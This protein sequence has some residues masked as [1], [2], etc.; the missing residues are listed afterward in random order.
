MSSS[1]H[2]FRSRPLSCLIHRLLTPHP[3]HSS[4][5]AVALLSASPMSSAATDASGCEENRP[6]W[7][8]FADAS[9]PEANPLNGLNI[10]GQSRHQLVD[11]DLDGDLDM[12]M[13]LET[14][15]VFYE[16]TGTPQQAVLA[17]SELSIPEALKREQSEDLSF[18]KGYPPPLSPWL[19]LPRYLQDI[20]NDGDLDI[21]KGGKTSNLMMYENQGHSQHSVFAQNPVGLPTCSQTNYHLGDLD[22]DGDLDMLRSELGDTSVSY[23]ENTGTASQ[24]EFSARSGLDDPVLNLEIPFKSS[25]ALVDVDQDRDLDILAGLENGRLQFYE[26]KGTPQSPSF[27][28]NS[29]AENPFAAVNVGSLATPSL[30]DLDKDGDLD[31]LVSNAEGVFTYYENTGSEALRP[32]LGWDKTAFAQITIPSSLSSTKMESHV[33]ALA[34]LDHDGDLDLLIGTKITAMTGDRRGRQDILY[35]ENVGSSQ[36]A[37]FIPR[38]EAQSP[39]SHILTEEA[40]S[41]FEGK[42]GAIAAAISLGDVDNDG[43]IDLLAGS[44]T[45]RLDYYENTGTPQEPVFTLGEIGISTSGDAHPALGD[46][47]ADGDLDVLLGG[48]DTLNFYLNTGSTSQPV[49]TAVQGANNPFQQI[50]QVDIPY[51]YDLDQD[52]DLD[53]FFDLDIYYENTGTPQQPLFTLQTDMPSSFKTLSPSFAP[54]LALGD[55]NHDGSPELVTQSL[56]LYE[57]LNSYTL[58]QPVE[59]VVKGGVYGASR[60]QSGALLVPLSCIQPCERILYS[61]DGSTPSLVYSQ[62]I[63][64]TQDTVLNFQAQEA[65]GTLSPIYTEHYVIDTLAPQLSITSLTEESFERSWP[66]NIKGVVKDNQVFGIQDIALQIQYEGFFV[67]NDRN[68]PLQLEPLWVSLKPPVNI[69]WPFSET[70]WRF[71]VLYN[72]GLM[73]GQFTITARATDYAGNTTITEPLTFFIEDMSS[74]RLSL[75]ASQHRLASNAPVFFSGQFLPFG[76]IGEGLAGHTVHLYAL[77]A[78]GQQIPTPLASTLTNAVGQYRFDEFSTAFTG[79]YTLTACLLRREGTPEKCANTTTVLVDRPAGYV[80]LL[81]A[82]ASTQTTAERIHHSFKQRDFVDQ[83]I[84]YLSEGLEAPS[85]AGFLSAIEQWA[86]ARLQT[87]PAPLYIVMLGQGQDNG[88]L[89][90]N[91]EVITAE[92]LNASLNALEAQLDDSTGLNEPRVLMIASPGSGSFIPQVSAPHRIVLTSMAADESL[93][94]ALADSGDVFLETLFQ[95]FSRGTSLLQAFQHATELTDA[96]SHQYTDTQPALSLPYFDQATQHPLLDDNADG[97]GTHLFPPELIAKE[98]LIARHLILGAGD[99]SERSLAEP[100]AVEVFQTD[101]GQVTESLFLSPDTTQAQLWLSPHRLNDAQATVYVR[102]TGISGTLSRPMTLNNG[103]YEWTE[104]NFQ[105][106]GRYDVFYTLQTPRAVIDPET[107]QALSPVSSSLIKHSVVYKQRPNNHIPTAIRLIDPPENNRIPPHH[108]FDWSTAT[109]PDGDALTYTLHIENASNHQPALHVTDLRLSHYTVTAR[110]RTGLN[111]EQ[112]AEHLGL[113]G[114]QDYLWW[115]EAV[116]AEGARSRSATESFSVFHTS[117]NFGV[118]PSLSENLKPNLRQDILR[119]PFVRMS[120]TCDQT[121]DFWF[122]A[123][124]QQDSTRTNVYHLLGFEPIPFTH[125]EAA[126]FE[127]QTLHLMM[128]SAY[129]AGYMFKALPSILTLEQDEQGV[130]FVP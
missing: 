75:T 99:S 18:P 95:H 116:D 126:C 111:A 86:A 107:Q 8:C 106:P 85:Q 82:S 88:V 83:D 103:R 73:R 6:H 120:Q 67:R 29:E 57:N 53:L 19:T 74:T 104:D 118:D 51:L 39:V 1:I 41:H 10:G 93:A 79:Q 3:W 35:Y 108:Q 72:L 60:V 17:P 9:A 12:L 97:I 119:L 124:L 2:S 36:L 69:S 23:C 128:P 11:F 91:G 71:N 90:D 7:M 28:L 125:T 62:A 68:K 115:V 33:P 47:D 20:D 4:V 22:G 122:S 117:Y 100:E 65:Q 61:L 13:T 87:A 55:L 16:N 96:L 101:I 58:P 45:G 92:A 38:F 102:G 24:A 63:E 123:D 25:L 130:L 84:R 49:F 98:G 64:I 46:I 52:G 48:T 30:G 32:V 5:W 40:S 114:G 105:T 78:Q 81:N 43:D 66:L 42:G 31:L 14:G 56:F 110:T 80:I 129:A 109:D 127:N 94:P 59:A 112:Q 121:T 27:T 76:R 34:D 21:L 113:V 50:P 26:N 15:T 89:L 37:V 77:D 44:V 70:E 54:S